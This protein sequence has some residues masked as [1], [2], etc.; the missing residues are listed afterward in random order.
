MEVG[1]GGVFLCEF[2]IWGWR[3]GKGSELFVERFID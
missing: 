1:A 3:D 2:L